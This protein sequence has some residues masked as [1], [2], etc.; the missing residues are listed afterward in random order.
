MLGR[1]SQRLTYANV[2]ATLALFIALGGASYAAVQ[3]PRN[4][5]GADQLRTGS[6]R[7]AEVRDR[8][9][10]LRDFSL[11]ARQALRGERGPAGPPGPSGGGASSL[12]LSYRTAEGTAPAVTAAG[13]G[14][15]T[16]TAT[17]DAGQRV[18]GGGLRV[19]SG[20]DTSARESYPNLGNTAWTVHAGNDGG[21]PS[22]YTVFAICVSG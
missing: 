21:V 1:L 17:C 5:V 6:V 15:S 20:D 9:L 4:S 7:S 14:L 8:S 12:G 10:A 19:D 18:V 22:T 11:A 13:S 2:T 3:I 16:T